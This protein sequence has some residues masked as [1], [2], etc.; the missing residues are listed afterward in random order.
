M[1]LLDIETAVGG[2]A[3]HGMTQCQSAGRFH[4]HAYAILSQ[5][6][7]L[8]HVV[9]DDAVDQRIACSLIFLQHTGIEA[10]TRPLAQIHA[11]AVAQSGLQHMVNLARHL[12]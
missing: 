10:G 4:I 1:H 9:G 7:Q 2:V 8:Y 6:H 12:T 11:R 3:L 5:F